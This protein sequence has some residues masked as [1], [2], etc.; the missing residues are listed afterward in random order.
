MAALTA[1]IDGLEARLATISGLRT[2]D[3]PADTV[4]PPAAIVSLPETVAYDRVLARGA[5]TWNLRVLVVVAKS[6]DR[7]WRTKMAQYLDGAGASSVKAAIEGDRTLG[8]AANTTRVAAATPGVF[9]IGGVDCWGATFDVE[10][11]A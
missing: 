6:T 1:I 2:Y 5:D 11:T 7:A 8:G 10:V 9:T 4:S 3:Y